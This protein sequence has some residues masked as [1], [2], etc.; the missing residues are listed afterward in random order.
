VTYYS[1]PNFVELGPD[2]IGGI[3]GQK[4]KKAIRE[5]CCVKVR[6]RDGSKIYRGFDNGKLSTRLR[7]NRVQIDGRPCI[8]SWTE[9]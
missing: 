1:D 2:D 9:V 3:E 7:P 8:K 5:V 6:I 4:S